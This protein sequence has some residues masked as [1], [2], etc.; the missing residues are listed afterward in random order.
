MSALQQNGEIQ[1]VKECT[2]EQAFKRLDDV[3]MDIKKY[4]PEDFNPE[5][6]LEAARTER[7]FRMISQ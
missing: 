3:R 6:E 4:L 1:S 5:R 7:Y 2:G